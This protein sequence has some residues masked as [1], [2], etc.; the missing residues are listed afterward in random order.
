VEIKSKQQ[1]LSYLKFNQIETD[2]YAKDGFSLENDLIK[3][4][5][6]DGVRYIVNMNPELYKNRD[7]I[8]LAAKERNTNIFRLIYDKDIIT[9]QD[10]LIGEMHCSYEVS[11]YIITK[12]NIDPDMKDGLLLTYAAINKDYKLVKLLLDKGADPTLNE[13]WPLI[14]AVKSGDIMIVK[15]LL[16]HGADSHVKNDLALKTAK[17]LHHRDIYNLLER[18]D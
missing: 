13:G 16:E 14:H 18:I 8:I 9:M 6:E 12:Y 10:L 3:R 7:S 2:D 1:F 11:K 4:Q 5:L 17:R 15:I